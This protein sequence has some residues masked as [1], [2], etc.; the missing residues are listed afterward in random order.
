MDPS[1][2]D[3][4]LA[5]LS[6]FCLTPERIKIEITERV[7]LHDMLLAGAQMERLVSSGIQIYID[8]FGTGYSNFAFVLDSPF[9]CV[10]IDRSLVKDILT[11]ERKD[12]TVKTLMKLF[13][14]I[15]KKLVI[16]GVE[17]EEQAVRV[18]GYGADM[19]QGF[20]YARPMPEEEFLKFI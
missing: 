18:K 12:L 16:E 15:G 5:C 8:D 11:D 6:R 2:A 1:L 10:K 20:F 7:L 17:N 19:I 3:T 4:I 14:E 13:H 9:E